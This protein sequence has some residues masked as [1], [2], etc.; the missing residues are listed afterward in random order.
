[1]AKLLAGENKIMMMDRNVMED[2]TKEWHDI[3]RK[4]ILERRKQTMA[5]GSG[6]G[7]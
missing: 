3:A 6:G 1:M 5:S 4:E 7:D 2:M